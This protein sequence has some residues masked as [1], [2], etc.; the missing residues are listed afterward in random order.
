MPSRRL[1]RGAELHGH[2]PVTGWEADNSGVRVQTARGEYRAR[3][4]IF[5]GGAWTDKLLRDLGVKLTVTRQ[6]LGWVWPK[7]P[8][9]FELGR[10]P[11]WS[12]DAPISDGGKEISGQYYG[13]PMLPDNPGFKIALHRPMSPTDPNHVCRDMLPGDEETFRPL[14]RN[15]IPDADGP[16]LALR[17]CLYTNSPDSHFILDTHPSHPNVTL[18]C[19]FSG[20]GFKFSSVIG[21]AM[22][23]L[24][25]DGRTSLPIE[26]LRLGRFPAPV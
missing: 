23:D 22:A 2:E 6:V 1:R 3:H 4:L 7:R 5:C 14:L 9:L 18:A 19:G 10:F 25:L 12:L 15:V 17:V 13:V 8:E 21:Q 24:A 16:L 26:F 20:H 11:I